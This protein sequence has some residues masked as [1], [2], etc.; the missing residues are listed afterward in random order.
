MKPH[1]MYGDEGMLYKEYT[2]SL[3][4]QGVPSSEI[5]SY[6]EWQESELKL[7]GENQKSEQ[8][9]VS[10][11]EAR[12]SRGRHTFAKIVGIGLAVYLST[13][14]YSCLTSKEPEDYLDQPKSSVNRP[15]EKDY[16]GADERVFE[17]EEG[18]PTEKDVIESRIQEGL[19][20]ALKRTGVGRILEDGTRD[21]KFYRKAMDGLKNRLK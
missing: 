6:R 9:Y 12:P 5:P 11:K 14:V 7:F 1:N 2:N 8:G 18:F 10:G 4:R 19:Q 21:Q 17:Q 16:V 3:A 13:R 20:R 15:V